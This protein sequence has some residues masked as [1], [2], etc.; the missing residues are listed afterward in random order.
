MLLSHENL[1]TTIYFS[2]HIHSDTIR[3]C[4]Q[5]PQYSYWYWKNTFCY[6]VPIFHD[7]MVAR[8]VDPSVQRTV[9]LGALPDELVEAPYGLVRG[10]YRWLHPVVVADSIGGGVD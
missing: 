10:A 2:N 1:N 6:R 4:Y 9:Q 7:D 5:L 3:Q 8:S